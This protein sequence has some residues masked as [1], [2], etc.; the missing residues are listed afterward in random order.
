[1]S[2]RSELHAAYDELGPEVA[3]L[4]ERIIVTVTRDRPRRAAWSV[5]LRAPL[6][7][8]A[9]LVV[10]AVV[11]GSLVGGRLIAD[12][13]S[14]S[15]PHTPAAPLTPLQKLEARPLH[16]ASLRSASD[17]PDGPYGSSGDLGTG[18]LHMSG[19]SVKLDT[20]W[21][22]YFYNF[23]YADGP[24]TGP[25]LVRARDVVNNQRLV[26]V[27]PHAAGP[28]VGTD[29]LDGQ[30]TE[31]RLE[32]VIDDVVSPYAWQFEVGVPKGAVCTGWQIDGPGFTE[33]FSL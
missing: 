12:L 3:G 8:V 11:A 25:I 19:S 9:V 5:R 10:I 4:G 27:G 29:V 6:S 30:V 24:V 26:F 17:C 31:Q 21:G 13:R 23:V 14:H 32:L 18:P 1:V 33:T 28:V 2:L 16:Q 20:N 15:A 7:L 22:S